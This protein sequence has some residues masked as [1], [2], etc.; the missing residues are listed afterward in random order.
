MPLVS[1]FTTHVSAM[2]AMPPPEPEPEPVAPDP[3][4]VTFS[5][6]DDADSPHFMVADDDDDEGT[7]MA[8]VNSEIMVESNTT[9]QI[10]PMFVDGA[11]SVGVDAGS[12]MPFAYVDNFDMLQSM[13]PERWCDLHG[14]ADHGRR[15]PGD[16]AV[17]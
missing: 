4:E 17:G 3:V 2:S 6:S 14:S 7:A 11:P 5:L 10:T 13:V 15:E 9:A 12:N 16:G 1:A 8:S